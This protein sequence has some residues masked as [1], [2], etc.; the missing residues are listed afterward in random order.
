VV[1]RV[2]GRV[3]DPVGQH[4]PALAAHGEG[5]HGTSTPSGSLRRECLHLLATA[6]A[7]LVNCLGHKHRTDEGTGCTSGW[8]TIIL[9]AAAYFGTGCAAG[10]AGWEHPFRHFSTSEPGA[11]L[12]LA[13]WLPWP[14]SPRAGGAFSPCPLR[15]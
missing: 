13:R 4:A 1:A 8:A 6:G 7:C 9:P 10:S 12:R 5:P 11:V 14:T 2:F 3:P 15:F